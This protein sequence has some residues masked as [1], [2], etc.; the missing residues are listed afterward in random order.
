MDAEWM[1]QAEYAR[2]RGVT[3]QAV[4]KLVAAGKIKLH[5]GRI[6]AAEADLALGETI[7]RINTPAADAREAPGLTR[8]RTVTEVYRARMAELQYERAL[9]NLVATEGVADAAAVC[10]E[11]MVRIVR[12]LST[13]TEE[14]NAAAA[15][16]GLPGVRTLLKTIEHDMLQNVSA[17]FAKLANDAARGEAI[18][19]TEVPE[20]AP[21]P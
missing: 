21:E 7:E 16:G 8:A 4:G 13:R 1:T 5:N 17:A 19:V 10:G 6:D 3:R 2:H 20:E 12:S 14:L 9:G 18:P 15:Q 11:T